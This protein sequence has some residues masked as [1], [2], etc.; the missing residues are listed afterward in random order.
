MSVQRARKPLLLDLIGF[1]ERSRAALELA[2]GNRAKGRCALAHSS[3]ATAVL[4]NLDHVGAMQLWD[5]FRDRYPGRLAIFTSL[6]EG[7]QP[8]EAPFLKKPISIEQFVALLDR[9]AKQSAHAAS[10]SESAPLQ[11]RVEATAATRRHSATL[12]TVRTAPPAPKKTQT[13]K[14]ASAGGDLATKTAPRR[15][16]GADMPPRKQQERGHPRPAEVA[17]ET[18]AGE[19]LI[20]ALPDID[21]TLPEDVAR[22]IYAGTGRPLGALKQVAEQ[23]AATRKAQ[24]VKIGAA[25][26]ITFSADGNLVWSSLE[27]ERFDALFA[28]TA[29][30]SATVVPCLAD[31]EKMAEGAAKWCVD[32]EAMLWRAACA[33]YCGK[34]PAGTD[35][36]LRV[37]LTRWPNLTRVLEIPNAVR[38][39]ALWAEQRLSLAFTAEILKIPQRYVFAFYGAAYAAGLCGPVKRSEDVVV[40]EAPI[41][42]NSRRG[43][44]A[45]ILGRLR[46]R[47][48]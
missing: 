5:K 16:A 23:V 41:E 24:R 7:K 38:I 22:R 1:E 4:V 2:I 11:V 48:A 43:L 28:E 37:Y 20:E 40:A 47:G 25:D 26:W 3:V 21:C 39:A 8:A 18:A 45:K 29:D 19:K 27:E 35:P 44:F 34:L 10:R 12:R 36:T 6:Y 32:A 17:A 42:P 33:T 31:E 30:I 46:G 13:L 15:A 9:L 14:L